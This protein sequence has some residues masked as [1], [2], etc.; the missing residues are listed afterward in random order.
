[1][2]SDA[3]TSAAQPA[4]PATKSVLRDRLLSRRQA[5]APVERTR[6]SQAVIQR[7]EVLPQFAA[8]LHVAA[9][10]PLLGEVDVLPVLSDARLENKR[11]YLPRLLAD[12]RLEF[13]VYH[14]TE[15]VKGPRGV[16]QPAPELPAVPVETLDFLVVPGLGFD[17][18]GHRLGLGAGYYDKTLAGLPQRPFCAGVGYDFQLVDALPTDEW[19][20]PLDA[21]VTERATIL[22]GR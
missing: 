17:R 1:M 4:S 8:A 19:D 5:L 15:L 10:V 16:M 21:V 12:G 6:R 20:I 3:S 22:I 14:P 11:V 9:Y 13:A 2:E 18:R 7:L